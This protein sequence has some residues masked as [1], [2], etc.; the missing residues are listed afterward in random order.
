MVQQ[1]TRAGGLYEM[2]CAICNEE[3]DPRKELDGHPVYIRE[4]FTD[5]PVHGDCYYDRL[6]ELV[7]KY[8]IGGHLRGRGQTV[9]K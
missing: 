1:E 6:G 7:E 5:K 4:D 8:P 9:D 2:K 3:I